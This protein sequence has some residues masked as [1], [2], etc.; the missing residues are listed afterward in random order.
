MNSFSHMTI[1]GYDEFASLFYTM[2]LYFFYVAVSY[3]LLLVRVARAYHNP[4]STVAR[5][6]WLHVC[7][8]LKETTAL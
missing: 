7:R 3:W 5:Q 6:T 8:L 2:S 4:V 1:Y